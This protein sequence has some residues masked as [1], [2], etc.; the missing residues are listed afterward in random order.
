MNDLFGD[1]DPLY[2]QELLDDLHA[3]ITA[4]VETPPGVWEA[5]PEPPDWDESE[6]AK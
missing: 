1:N 4:V 3:T 6:A 5:L 2:T